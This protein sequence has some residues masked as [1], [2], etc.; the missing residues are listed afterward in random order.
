MEKRRVRIYKAGGEQGSYINKT[1]QYFQ[2]GGIPQEQQAPAPTD[3]QMIMFI[4]QTL[5]QPNGSIEQA[6][7]QLLQ[8][9]IPSN[10][11]SELSAIALNY[12]QEQK[13]SEEAPMSEEMPQDNTAALEQEELENTAAQQ[14]QDSLMSQIYADDTSGED[15][16]DQ[17][18]ADIVMR[19]GG[20]ISKRK[21]MDTFMKL[22]KKQEGGDSNKK[23][24]DS[25]DI[26]LRGRE[27]RVNN[28]LGSIKNEANTAALKQQAEEQYNQYMQHLQQ[29]PM[30]Q[31]Y[32][33]D[34]GDTESGVLNFDPYHNLEHY[35]GAFEHSMPFNQLTQAQFGGWGHGKERRAARKLNRM[36][37]RGFNPMMANPFMQ[38]NNPLAQFMP[39]QG[40]LG[41]ANIDVRRTGIFGRPK[42]YTIN[43]NQPVYNNTKSEPA[44]QEIIKDDVA[45]KEVVVDE[46]A[47]V[48]AEET[49]TKTALPT[50]DEIEIAGDKP[51]IKTGT[52]PVVQKDK[53]PD[54]K[55]SDEKNKTTD[56][57]KTKPPIKV[58]KPTTEEQKIIDL[59]RANNKKYP[60][61]YNPAIDPRTGNY[62]PMS[63]GEDDQAVLDLITLGMYGKAKLAKSTLSQLGDF[64]F[65][66]FAKGFLPKGQGLLNSGKG[67]LNSG[68]SMLN[69]GQGMLNPGQGLLNPQRGFQYSLPFQQGGF[70]DE[71]S[72]L[73]RFIG[74]GEDMTQYDL[75]YSDSKNISS[76]YF[77]KGGY[78]QTAGQ[79]D[80]TVVDIL[81]ASGNVV[82]K[83]TLAEAE[84]AGLNHRS[85]TT[86]TSTTNTNQ[87]TNPQ[88]FDYAQQYLQSL[89]MQFN[90]F[91][92]MPP[93]SISRGANWNKAIGRPYG[94]INPISGMIGPNAQVSSINVNKSRLNGTPKKFTVN[95]NIPGQP[96]IHA[97]GTPKSYIGSDGQTH[98]MNNDNTN[99]NVN[100]APEQSW[101]DDR[102][103]RRTERVS[104]WFG[105]HGKDTWTN[106]NQSGEDNIFD[107]NGM[108]TNDYAPGVIDNLRKSP[109]SA[110]QYRIDQAD[111]NQADRQAWDLERLR[112]QNRAYGGVTLPQAQFGNPQTDVPFGYF[113]D[114][115]TG[116]YKNLAGEIYSP[117]TNLQGNADKLMGN[118][119]TQEGNG[120]TTDKSMGFDASGTGYRNEGLLSDEE[121]QAGASQQVSQKFKNKQEWNIDAKGAL[122][123]FNT[124]GNWAANAIDTWNSTK[125]N[126]N[127][128]NRYNA[129][130][131]YATTYGTDK[132][133]WDQEG[134]FRLDQEGDNG[135]RIGRE[136]GSPQNEETWMSE[137]QIRQFLAE[138]GELEFI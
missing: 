74:G 102:N 11:V 86:N 37:P 92:F 42:E 7:Q 38:G 58:K 48:V 69:P 125:Q 6:Q 59:I 9:N 82:R 49:V 60:L 34:G 127:Q 40:N 70:T 110:S 98:W 32:A 115:K 2:E 106:N 80:N 109:V 97:S 30:M 134:R 14:R 87:N 124:A 28:F 76:P 62:R 55:K 129:D 72:G 130:Q 24:I 77:Q 101:R 95:Y 57:T 22:A 27:E 4:M 105:E 31:D 81:D 18:E 68:K 47:P 107:E 91:A 51:V 20:P 25:T 103:D 104:K 65:K 83:G 54:V 66:P 75:D 126:R 93:S 64:A 111:E 128:G 53:V 44:T 63:A 132:G 19:K 90:P 3:E 78:F 117:K 79:T 89:G 96:G 119:F 13:G 21:Y 33:Q 1:Q 122:D 36:I 23:P 113:K 17:A 118:D 135:L 85:P 120:L 121:K 131:L 43:F 137:E 5:S 133:D 108:P 99:N 50:V 45:E 123:A 10:K 41:L 136:G 16:Y 12:I 46:A 73:Y 52:T 112:L 29:P 100:Q 71:E 26:P 35:S 114:P 56:G 116:V 67:L 94:T 15:V 8:S 84:R 61:G 138:G 88:N 39:N